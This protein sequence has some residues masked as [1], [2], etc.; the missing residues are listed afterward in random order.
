[1]DAED[2]CAHVLQD[3]MASWAATVGRT[4]SAQMVTS[5]SDPALRLASNV[6]LYVS[7]LNRS[8]IQTDG[9][10]ATTP[11]TPRAATSSMAAG[12]SGDL[13]APG[14]LG[15]GGSSGSVR[16]ATDPTTPGASMVWAPSL[17]SPRGSE[18]PTP[19]K[20]RRVGPL[21]AEQQLQRYK[22]SLGRNPVSSLAVPTG[23]EAYPQVARYALAACCHP[24]ELDALLRFQALSAD[25]LER[26]R[27]VRTGSSERNG[28]GA[29]WAEHAKGRHG[30]SMHKGDMGGAC[31]RATWAEHAQG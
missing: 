28:G 19:A 12:A 31:A 15:G 16:G 30:R 26:C 25:E 20:M 22:E 18:T 13:L 14:D 8:M 27:Y 4:G 24:S 3:G 2:E 5:E 29:T 21:S 23:F 9:G 11:S 1:M 6:W 10:T 17:A 7:Q